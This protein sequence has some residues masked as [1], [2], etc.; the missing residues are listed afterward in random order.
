MVVSILPLG[1]GFVGLFTPPEA[2]QAS[3]AWLAAWLLFWSL[4]VRT[5][6][7]HVLHPQPRPG[8]GDHQRLPGPQPGPGRCAWPFCFC[9]RC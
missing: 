8:D 1:L 6:V 7:D 9:F 4:W 3:Q 5:F 2:I